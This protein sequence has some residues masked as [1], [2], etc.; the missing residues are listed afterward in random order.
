MVGGGKR[1]LDD[2]FP[3]QKIPKDGGGVRPMVYLCTIPALHSF[4]RPAQITHRRS[5]IMARALGVGGVSP[6]DELDREDGEE[7]SR[8]LAEEEEEESSSSSSSSE[9]GRGRSAG[10]PSDAASSS[11]SVGVGS[12]SAAARRLWTGVPLLLSLAAGAYHLIRRGGGH[13]V[14]VSDDAR[15]GE[16]TTTTASRGGFDGGAAFTREHLVAAREE[17]RKVLSLLEEYYFG[18]DQAFRMLM[19]SWAV[20]WD[21]GATAPGKRD[22]TAKL[23]DTMARALVTDG[24]RTFLMGGIG[25]SAM[26]GHENCNYDGYQKQMERLWQPVWEAA[27]MDFVFQNAGGGEE[28]GDTRRDQQFCL[29]QNISPDVD[30]IH[31][32]FAHS[33]A[34]EAHVQHENLIRWAQLL[35]KQPIVHILDVGPDDPASNPNHPFHQLAR[36]YAK[37]GHNIFGLRAA[38]ERGGHDYESETARAVDPFDRFDSGYVG[39]G[40]HDTTRYGELEDDEVRRDSLGVVMRSADKVS[41]VSSVCF[42]CNRVVVI[43]PTSFVASYCALT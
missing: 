15:G 7:R 22:R 3:R 37:Y 1:T 32:S 40:Y 43:A 2:F 42:C 14:R 19:T 35:P 27:G 24:Q 31:Y 34:E 5:N 16:G 4:T 39:D 6:D 36:Y 8:M 33:E 41:I 18:E 13:E 11:S 10:E 26:A 23:V 25:S 38:L 29:K 9:S 28:C 12:S 17:G 30:V 21:F 20:V